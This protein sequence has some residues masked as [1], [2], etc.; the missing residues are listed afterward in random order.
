M[1][2]EFNKMKYSKPLVIINVF[3]S[4]NWRYFNIIC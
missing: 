1:A 2:G 3:V 4:A